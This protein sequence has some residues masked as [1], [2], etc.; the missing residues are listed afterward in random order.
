[1]FKVT[2]GFLFFIF[3][4]SQMCPCRAKEEC[5]VGW[6]R[7]IVQKENYNISG[8]SFCSGGAHLVSIISI[9]YK[10]PLVWSYQSRPLLKWMWKNSNNDENF[11]YRVGVKSCNENFLMIFIRLSFN[12]IYLESLLAL[13][14]S[15]FV[16]ISKWSWSGS[17]YALKFKMWMHNT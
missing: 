17:F 8:N 14:D 7:F 16:K 12:I 4:W 10:S 15:F 5:C 2:Q 11:I 13:A 1:M 3:F 9:T 6:P